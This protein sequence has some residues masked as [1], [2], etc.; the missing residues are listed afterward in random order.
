MIKRVLVGTMIIAAIATVQAVAQ[1][2]T[3]RA[4]PADTDGD[5]KVTLE[6][7]KAMRAKFDEK[8]GK[9]TPDAITEKQFAARDKNGD[10]VLTGEEAVPKK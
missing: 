2:S 1:E 9:K 5:G 10:G 4:G 6:E 3:G 7:F 8:S